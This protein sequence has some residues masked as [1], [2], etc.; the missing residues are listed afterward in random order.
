MPTETYYLMAKETDQAYKRLTSDKSHLKSNCK[1]KPPYDCSD[2][3][4]RSKDQAIMYLAQNGNEYTSYYWQLAAPKV[5]G[6]R[7][8]IDVKFT[9]ADTDIFITPSNFTTSS[10]RTRALSS[11]SMV[12]LAM[13]Q[14]RGPG[15]ALSSEA[16]LM[17]HLPT[18]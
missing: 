10:P 11:L 5:Y 17:A 6:K 13:L 1:R 14:I 15:L 7:E 9:T 3:S 18:V 2:I 16:I 12:V 8:C 4:E